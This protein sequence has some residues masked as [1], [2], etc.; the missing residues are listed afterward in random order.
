MTTTTSIRVMRC[1]RGRAG[2]GN[3]A[4]RALRDDILCFE[5][6]GDVPDE[7]RVLSALSGLA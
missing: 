6:H 7:A 2:L 5:G 3:C 4:F 1:F